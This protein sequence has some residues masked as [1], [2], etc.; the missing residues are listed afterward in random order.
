MHSLRDVFTGCELK[1]PSPFMELF[2]PCT[3][4][5]A[6]SQ[7]KG[8]RIVGKHIQFYKKKNVAA[9]ESDLLS[10]LRPFAPEVPISGPTQLVVIW[11][12]PYRKSE[13][14]ALVKAGVLIPNNTR[15]DLDNLSKLLTDALVRLRF[16]EDDGQLYVV[17]LEK[18]WGPSPGI[19]VKI[20]ARSECVE[21][22]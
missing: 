19:R 16:I 11:T 10:M 4:P 12:F 7:Q 3:P 9:A 1:T 20:L 5:K 18:Y 17:T 13:R 6:T 8:A 21:T 2:I 14:K 22:K 15:P